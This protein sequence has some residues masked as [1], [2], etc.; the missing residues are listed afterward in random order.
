MN[1]TG[2]RTLVGRLSQAQGG[3]GDALR[4]NSTLSQVGVEIP[5]G[6]TAGPGTG[7][8]LFL[9]TN[10]DAA[11]NGAIVNFY[12]LTFGHE[13]L[14]ESVTLSPADIAAQT[15]LAITA[16]GCAADFW[17]VK[18][19]LLALPTA[20]LSTSLVAFGYENI[21]STGAVPGGPPVTPAPFILLD[22]APGG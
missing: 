19:V 4:Q 6:Q 5:L 3:N 10:K 13:A 16:S 12:V 14:F 2:P 21:T 8:T 20:S 11:Y 15:S 18:I 1:P 17:E 7:C 9:S 22:A